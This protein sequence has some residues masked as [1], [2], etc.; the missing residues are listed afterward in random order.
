MTFYRDNAYPHT[1]NTYLTK[2]GV[3]LFRMLDCH[4]LRRTWLSRYCLHSRPDSVAYY[5][6]HSQV[7]P[8]RIKCYESHAS[9]VSSL[10]HSELELSNTLSMHTRLGDSCRSNEILMKSISLL[11]MDISFACLA[12]NI[13]ARPES[14]C[15]IPYL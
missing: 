7:H 13:A 8:E 12:R 14:E 9:R 6:C 10:S 3:G 4:Y 2:D 15:P 5:S 1:Q 11:L